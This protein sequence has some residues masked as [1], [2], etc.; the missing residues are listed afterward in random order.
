MP[1]GG[2]MASW[3][4]AHMT[5]QRGVMVSRVTKG[6]EPAMK[7]IDAGDVVLRVGDKLVSSPKD[8]WDAIDSARAAGRPFVPMLIQRKQPE[9]PGPDW[10]AVRVISPPG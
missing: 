3:G 1:S 9:H 5:M 2:I 8:V 7:K 10:V 4:K 6:S